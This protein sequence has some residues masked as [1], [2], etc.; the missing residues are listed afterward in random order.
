MEYDMHN[1]TLRRLAE[2]SLT[3]QLD[4]RLLRAAA[5]EGVTINDFLRA[6]LYMRASAALWPIDPRAVSLEEQAIDS[7]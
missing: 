3:G 2:E 1:N 5:A 6:R 4:P 7:N